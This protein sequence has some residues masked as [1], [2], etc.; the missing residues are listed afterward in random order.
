MLAIEE[1][2]HLEFEL[3]ISAFRAGPAF[4]KEHGTWSYGGALAMRI[5]F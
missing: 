4:G 5:S 2:Q 1:W 3:I